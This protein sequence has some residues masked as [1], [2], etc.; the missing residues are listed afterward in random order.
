MRC[1]GNRRLRRR[2]RGDLAR[3]NRRCVPDLRR[4]RGANSP[5][6]APAYSREAVT[7]ITKT[8][9]PQEFVFQRVHQVWSRPTV[10]QPGLASRSPS[11]RTEPPTPALSS[12][13]ELRRRVRS[14]LVG[15][16]TLCAVACAADLRPTGG[17]GRTL[18]PTASTLRW[19]ANDVVE[20][21]LRH[22]QTA[23]R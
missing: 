14:H 11:A 20:G 4:G 1:A 5:T 7:T 18:S 15:M 2:L 22:L 23:K 13:G 10:L 21:G 19:R 3:T 6:T 16:A 12:S 8:C 17:P 9:A